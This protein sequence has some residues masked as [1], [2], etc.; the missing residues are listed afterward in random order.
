LGSQA[1]D[2]TTL[3][4]HSAEQYALSG[5]RFVPYHHDLACNWV[6]GYSFQRR[7]AMLVP[8][9]SAYYALPVSETGENPPFAYETSNGCALGRN[10]EEAIFHGM[11]EVVERDAFLLSWYGRLRL[12]RLD[13]RSVTDTTI[14]L[15]IEH[16]EYRTGYSIYV[17]NAT[18]DHAFPCL[19][20]MGI[21]EKSRAGFPKIRCAAGSHLHPELALQRALRELSMFLSKPSAQYQ[22]KRPQALEMLA[23]PSLVKTLPDHPL[24]YCLP[25]AFD[26]LSFLDVTQSAQTFQEAFRTFYCERP[27]HMDLRDDLCMLLDYYCK[28]GIDCIVVEQTA[29]EYAAQQLRS[30]KVLMPGMLPMTFGHQHRRITGIERLYQLPVALGYRDH[31]LTE[32]EINPYPHP[33]S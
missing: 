18:L 21:D 2:P 8:E 24:L 12:P 26:R 20:V 31:P 16:I 6:W 25:E 4:L 3:G 10:L 7:C 1:L 13:P 9:R 33:F 5:Y 29:P 15:L 19:W 27:M 32:A 11:L 14:R 30:V 28:R 22:Q 23:D 17:F